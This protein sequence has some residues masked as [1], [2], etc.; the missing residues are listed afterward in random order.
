M[1]NTI[2]SQKNKKQ[3]QKEKEKIYENKC[4][5]IEKL[6]TQIGCRSIYELEVKKLAIRTDLNDILDHENLKL[7]SQ[8]KYLFVKFHLNVSGEKG[9]D[10]GLYDSFDQFSKIEY[11]KYFQRIVQKN[12][13]DMLYKYLPALS[14]TMLYNNYYNI[15]T[16]Y[17]ENMYYKKSNGDDDIKDKIHDDDIKDKNKKL[18]HDDD[19][20]NKF[21]L[22]TI[23]GRLVI[24]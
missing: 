2:T 24:N 9:F 4:I 14:F 11:K 1:G 21:K 8:C 13:A 6:K 19:I 17:F 20:V 16:V 12:I 3:K 23:D 15:Y 18:I 7:I 10:R 22:L 5:E